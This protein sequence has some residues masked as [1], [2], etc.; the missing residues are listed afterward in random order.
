V[1]NWVLARRN[2]P[3]E[4]LQGGQDKVREI[5]NGSPPDV[6]VLSSYSPY[7]EVDTVLDPAVFEANLSSQVLGSHRVSSSQSG[8][9]LGD[10]SPTSLPGNKSSV[11]FHNLGELD[12]E[13]EGSAKEWSLQC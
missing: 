5:W 11:L 10:P 2:S 3:L 7:A 1:D 9:E 13:V 8:E 4:G 12:K 6:L